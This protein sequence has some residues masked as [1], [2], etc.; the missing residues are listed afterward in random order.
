MQTKRRSRVAHQDAR[1]QAA[2]AENLETVADA[3]HIAA[4]RGM[5]AHRVHDLGA[6]GDGAAAQIVAIGKTAG[7]DDEIGSGGQIVIV[8]PDDVA[9]PAPA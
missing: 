8:V 6:A 5:G 1:Q 4:A 3:E 2:F 9:V 7:Q